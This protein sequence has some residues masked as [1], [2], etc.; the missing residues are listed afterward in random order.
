MR[1]LPISLTLLALSACLP[2]LPP[3]DTDADADADTDPDTDTDTDSPADF[4]GDGYTSDVDC[5]DDDAL[6]H[7]DAVEVCDGA[8]TD[9]NGLIDDGT[10]CYDDDGDGYTE[11]DGDCDDTTALSSP[12]VV[13]ACDGVDHDCDGVVDEDDSSDAQ[14]W[15][16]DT[17]GDSFGDPDT[18]A[19]AC[20]QPS[21]WVADDSDCAD[22]DPDAYP[23]APEYCDGGDTNCD[24][25][26]NQADS[27]DAG[28][29]YL[30]ADHDGYGDSGVT[31]TSC[32]DPT[33]YVTNAADCD[34]TEVTTNPGEAEICE[35][36]ID[37]DCDGGS[38]A[39]APPSES[40]STAVQYTGEAWNDRAGASVTGVGDVNADGHDDM[41]IG[42]S[43]AND[44]AGS[45]VGGAYLV[46]GSSTPTSTDLAD[47]VKYTGE[48]AGDLA[49]ISVSAGDVDGDGLP[50]FV[51][52]A[53][54]TDD[55]AADAGGAYLILGSAPRA[56]ASLST[57]LLYWGE[58]E[59]D[60]AGRGVAVVGD[61]DADGF[62][63]VLVGGWR[64]SGGG[65]HAG[66][67]YLVRGQ[68]SLASA[69]LS[70]AVKYTGEAAGDGAGFSVAG[71]GDVDGDGFDDMLVGGMNASSGAGAAYFIA[72]G[73][74][75]SVSLSA[76]VKYSGQVADGA[77]YSVAGAGDV[78]GD[79]YVDMLVGANWGAGYAG[80]AYLVLGS[81][82]PVAASLST[83]PVFS[84]EASSDQAGYS[85]A[86]AGDVD[87]DGFADFLVGAQGASKAYLV[88]GSP[89][90]ASE[91]LSAA[92]VLGGESSG[93]EVGSSVAGAGDVDGDGFPDMLVGAENAEGGSSV[94]AAYLIFGTGM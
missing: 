7:P 86:G 77:G 62:D 94:G 17:D 19:T 63:D 61:V 91:S 58:E 32:A 76:G 18:L 53:P 59:Y 54:G 46:L 81:G 11:A 73:S 33:G 69:S 14:A 1:S 44:G 5:D 6:I 36:G 3:G 30:D 57:A 93:D 71:A 82:A 90:P 22:S 31:V 35:D 27:V 67:A 39:C 84:G 72:G 40:L 56:S 74:P 87:A 68:A 25:L 52:G 29:W 4:D 2:A 15:H 10:T 60:A 16:A 45:D 89:A 43:Y 50:D 41:L 66:A 65:S 55:G 64:N 38:G 24:S 9:C 83:V 48:T 92:T 21:N 20:T 78:D 75:T 13:D 51:L 8:D 80:C 23:G 49:G 42:A 70:T 28:V 47:V 79:G 37:N 85:V 12:A 26:T 88:L 34:D